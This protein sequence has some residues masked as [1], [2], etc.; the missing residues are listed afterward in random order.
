MARKLSTEKAAELEYD[1][2]LSELVLPFIDQIVLRPGYRGDR[3]LDVPLESRFNPNMSLKALRKCLVKIYS[4]QTAQA[5]AEAI[6]DQRH[7]RVK[8]N[9]VRTGPFHGE[10]SGLLD[11]KKTHA[12]ALCLIHA[13]LFALESSDFDFS[14]LRKPQR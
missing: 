13:I 5:T 2:E 11:N 10:L 14:E 3:E 8:R 9:T 6:V 1:S 4:K 7:E 12:E